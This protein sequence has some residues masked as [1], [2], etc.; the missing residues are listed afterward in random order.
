MYATPTGTRDVLHDEL[1]ELRQITDA[2][3]RVYEDRGY[4]EVR[5]PA[6][7]FD[8]VLRR[9]AGDVAPGYRVFDDHGNVMALRPDMT[10]PIAR[11]GATRFANA[12]VP[13]RFSYLAHVYRGVRPHRGETREIQQSGIELLGAGAPEGTIEVLSVM[14]QALDA[15]GLRDYQ[16]A[17]GSAAVYPQLLETLD[18]PTELRPRLLDAL[19]AGDFVTLR[20]EIGDAGLASELLR[21][22]RLRGTDAV[23]DQLPGDEGAGLRN[24][25]TDLPDALRQRV[26]VDLGL[27]RGFGYYTGAVFDVLHPALGSP[28]GGGGRYDDLVGRFGR[29]LPAVGFALEVDQIHSALMAEENQGSR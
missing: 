29:E 27:V 15:V 24:V 4:G 16:I 10:V 13:L 25:V 3:R 1:R 8:D 2:L 5:T 6:I 14:A 12:E 20:T 17:I 28:V 23:I 22:P 18:V 7:E 9:G 19:V 21:I 11:L 26:V